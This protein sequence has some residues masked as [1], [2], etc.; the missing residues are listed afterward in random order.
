[1][2]FPYIMLAIQLNAFSFDS[3]FYFIFKKNTYNSYFFV[4]KTICVKLF[5]KYLMNT[6]SL[7][8]L[9]SSINYKKI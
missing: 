4:Q 2:Y 7:I 8:S 5:F 9:Y 6:F 3:Y 1:M